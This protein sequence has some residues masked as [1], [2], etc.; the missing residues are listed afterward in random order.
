[1]RGSRASQPESP[2]CLPTSRK[3]PAT[4]DR[5]TPAS[6]ISEDALEY[7]CTFLHS[8]NYGAVGEGEGRLGAV[9]TE[10][11]KE[12]RLQITNAEDENLRTWGEKCRSEVILCIWGFSLRWVVYSSFSTMKRSAVCQAKSPNQRE[13]LTPTG[14]TSPNGLSA[15]LMFSLYFCD[16]WTLLLFSHCAM[17]RLEQPFQSN[18]LANSLWQEE[19]WKR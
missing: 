7:S 2:G 6:L 3:R 10:R 4:D 15:H 13:L 14:N 19:F 9:R 18:S 8:L 12:V 11:G 1:M 17:A 16:L 5:C